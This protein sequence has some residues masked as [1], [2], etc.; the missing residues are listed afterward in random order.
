MLFIS[1][2][3]LVASM[4]FFTTGILAE[5]LTRTFYASGDNKHH[6]VG[7]QSNPATADWKRAG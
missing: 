3:F 4:Q 5:M 6:R 2:L 7:W 1:I